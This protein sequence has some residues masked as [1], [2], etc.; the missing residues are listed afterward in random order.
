[1]VYPDHISFSVTG[2]LPPAK[3]TGAW[4]ITLPRKV[5]T[6]NV[7]LRFDARESVPDIAGLI[8]SQIV[9]GRGHADDI[10]ADCPECAPVTGYYVERAAVSINL[11]RNFAGVPVVFSRSQQIACEDAIEKL[12]EKCIA[13]VKPR[14]TTTLQM[15]YAT[16]LTEACCVCLQE[17]PPKEFMF[18]C[19]TCKSTVYCAV[20]MPTYVEKFRDCAVCKTPITHVTEH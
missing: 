5:C 8:D 11:I 15:L 6:F 4:W 3:D 20:C 13:A 7:K 19:T 1:M 17:H 9:V 12:A 16:P 14:F 18:K 10:F 2:V